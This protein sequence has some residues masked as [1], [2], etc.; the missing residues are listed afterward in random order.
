MRVR[1]DRVASGYKMDLRVGT[2]GAV[3]DI[4]SGIKFKDPVSPGLDSST[5]PFPNDDEKDIED[6]ST[7]VY[8]QSDPDKSQLLGISN[9]DATNPERCSHKNDSDVEKHNASHHRHQ[10]SYEE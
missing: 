8:K 7:D 4:N 6:L 10:E 3:L 2:L 1:K 5:E 9:M